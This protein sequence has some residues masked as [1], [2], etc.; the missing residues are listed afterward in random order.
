MQYHMSEKD[1]FR[2]KAKHFAFSV[3]L[4]FFH[5]FSYLLCMLTHVGIE[6]REA[7]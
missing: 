4:A 2:T 3:I 5:I 6:A 1:E 7:N